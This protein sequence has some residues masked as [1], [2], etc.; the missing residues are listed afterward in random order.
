LLAIIYFYYFYCVPLTGWQ[1]IS[2]P[3]MAA[4]G[5]L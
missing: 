2:W 4:R 5:G 3:P 1:I